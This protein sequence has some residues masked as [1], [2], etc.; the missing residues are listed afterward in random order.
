MLFDMFD[1]QLMEMIPQS[2][3]SL[4]ELPYIIFCSNWITAVRD[5]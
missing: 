2:R 4:Q 1:P 5:P 3:M